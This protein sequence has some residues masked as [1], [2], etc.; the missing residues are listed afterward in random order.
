MTDTCEGN[1]CRSAVSWYISWAQPPAASS[2]SMR[3]PLAAVRSVKELREVELEGGCGWRQYW[4]AL[5]LDALAVSCKREGGSVRLIR[6][7]QRRIYLLSAIL[8]QANS[9]KI[10]ATLDFELSLLP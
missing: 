6:I 5:P 3:L 10:A 7:Y 8:L 1:R 2:A 9:S 4:D